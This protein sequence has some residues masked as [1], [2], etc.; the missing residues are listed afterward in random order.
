LRTQIA[1][2]TE[3]SEVIEDMRLDVFKE[4]ERLKFSEQHRA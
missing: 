1:A 2:L 4:K 3:K